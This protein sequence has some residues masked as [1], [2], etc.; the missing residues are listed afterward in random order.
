MFRQKYLSVTEIEDLLYASDSDEENDSA[1][2]KKTEQIDVVILPPDTVDA[3]S[4]DEEID[5]DV[6]LMSN[7]NV[8]L[9]E[10]AGQL[11][12]CY[13]FDDGNEI[14]DGTKKVL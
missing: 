4:D 6:Q 9:G 10:T 11:E 1:Q 3:I 2:L 14:T 5:E 8:K 7:Q 12:L 13:Q